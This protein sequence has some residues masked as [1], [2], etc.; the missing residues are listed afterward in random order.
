MAGKPRRIKSW[1]INQALREY[2]QR[3]EQ[4]QLRWDETLRANEAGLFAF[5]ASGSC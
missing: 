2:M 5:C 4:E 1:L 3:Q